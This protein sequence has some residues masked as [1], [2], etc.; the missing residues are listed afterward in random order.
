MSDDLN[1]SGIAG[2]LPDLDRAESKRHPLPGS[3]VTPTPCQAWSNAARSLRR[4][5]HT[6]PTLCV[7]IS[8]SLQASRSNSGR[9]MLWPCASRVAGPRAAGVTTAS[10]QAVASRLCGGKR[11]LVRPSV[12]TAKGTAWRV[13]CV[14]CESASCSLHRSV[15]QMVKRGS[16][17]GHS[18]R[19]EGRS[20]LPNLACECRVK[21]GVSWRLADLA[22]VQTVHMTLVGALHC[23]GA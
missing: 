22:C 21:V 19:S 14:A 16:R 18:S 23:G 20:Q 9:G 15:W 11:W 5:L 13:P 3:W 2:G 4:A 7:S 8:A 17:G 10:W 12:T 1:V 6:S